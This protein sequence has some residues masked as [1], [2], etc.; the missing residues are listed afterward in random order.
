MEVESILS[1][2]RHSVRAST[3]C[4]YLVQSSILVSILGYEFGLNTSKDQKSCTRYRILCGLNRDY[5][6]MY[7]S[8]SYM[9]PH[10]LISFFNSL[11]LSSRF[12]LNPTATFPPNMSSHKTS[13]VTPTSYRETLSGIKIPVLGYGVSRLYPTRSK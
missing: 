3:K 7:Q 13:L 4:I 1:G 10:V 6:T 2:L 9:P 8:Q 12:N 5:V 11:I